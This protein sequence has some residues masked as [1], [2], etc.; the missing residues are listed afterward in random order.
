[1]CLVPV[2]DLANHRTPPRR[3]RADAAA[4]PVALSR[5][6][7]GAITLAAAADLA[8]G[9]EVTITYRY[10]GNGQLLLDYG[11][12]E[13]LAPDAQQPSF[14]PLALPS[15]A[16]SP[17]GAPLVLGTDEADGPPLAELR[18]RLLQRSSSGD[19]ECSGDEDRV[20]GGAGSA[21]APPAGRGGREDARDDG[22]AVCEAL[23]R[24]C[25]DE[26]AGRA[27]SEPEDRAALAAL[28]TSCP[29]GVDAGRWRSI[30]AYRLAQKAQLRQT[31]RALSQLLSS[32]AAPGALGLSDVRGVLRASRSEVR[33][34]F[35]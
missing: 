23:A 12:A 28:A 17:G 31:A 26:L 30:L 10:E 14:E 8:A 33:E 25:E 20:E 5:E 16:S 15:L 27:T 13:H 2:V 1:M 4:A 3:G 21:A 6:D 32:R 9:E 35:Q 29:P 24:A 19:E 22:R 7:G 34:D 11:F 18:T